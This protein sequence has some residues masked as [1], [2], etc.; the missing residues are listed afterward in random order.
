MI[1]ILDQYNLACNNRLTLSHKTL[2]G[3]ILCE[4]S[5]FVAESEQN[6]VISQIMTLKHTI[7][8]SKHIK[9]SS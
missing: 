9:C 2:Y 5:H 4:C 8:T 6:L 1:E 7:L 3:K